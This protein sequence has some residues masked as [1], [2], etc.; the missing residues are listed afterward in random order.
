MCVC[1]YGSLSLK[2]NT[3]KPRA[4]PSDFTFHYSFFPENFPLF[5]LMKGRGGFFGTGAGGGERNRGWDESEASPLL[6][7]GIMFRIRFV[8]PPLVK[9]YFFSDA[10]I[11]NQRGKRNL[12]VA[13]TSDLP[14]R[15]GDVFS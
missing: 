10:R 13:V 7:R 1:V 11:S 2:R 3:L 12:D 9:L 4:L 15:A 5:S 8:F 6:L 14:V